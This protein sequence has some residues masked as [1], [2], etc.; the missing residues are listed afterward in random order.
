MPTRVVRGLVVVG[1]ETSARDGLARRL[2]WATIS[3]GRWVADEG[4]LGWLL[5]A[6]E[7]QPASVLRESMSAYTGDKKNAPSLVWVP[8]AL[9]HPFL[10]ELVTEHSN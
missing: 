3:G 6:F 4:A 2:R 10:W 9:P 1:A 8:F 7:V 5:R